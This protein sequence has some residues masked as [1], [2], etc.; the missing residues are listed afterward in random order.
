MIAYC[1]YDESDWDNL[2]G[3][4]NDF[5]SLADKEIAESGLT[6]I[7][8][9]ALFDPLRDGIAES[10]HRYHKAGINVRLVT[11]DQIDTAITIA[12]Q[13]NIITDE[14]LADSEN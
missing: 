8:I 14:D 1:D 2:K 4:A 10:V 5:M 11:G 13:A 7:G 3:Q 12:K 9:F 6:M